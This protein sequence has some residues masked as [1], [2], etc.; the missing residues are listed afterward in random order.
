MMRALVLIC[1]VL[2]VA[3]KQEPREMK[4][5]DDYIKDLTKDGKP[6][7]KQA[8]DFTHPYPHLQEDN[9]F[10]NDYTKDSNSDEGE[11]AAQME[12]DRLRAMIR[13]QEKKLPLLKEKADVALAR[14]EDAMGQE[15]GV[16]K[17][18]KMEEAPAEIEVEEQAFEA[19]E[20]EKTADEEVKQAVA[21]EEAA[22]EEE[23]EAKKEEE[24]KVDPPKEI[25]KPELKEAP[26]QPVIEISSAEVDAAVANLKE[27]EQ[28]V[29]DAKEKLMKSVGERAAL[30]KALEEAEAGVAAAKEKVTGAQK[31]SEEAVSEEK[32]AEGKAASADAA[33]QKEVQDVDKLKADMD[34]AAY[35]IKQMRGAAADSEGAIQGESMF[36]SGAAHSVGSILFALVA[37]AVSL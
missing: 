33:Y 31:E 2:T 19:L 23:A 10:D 5:H 15:E 13:S 14:Y 17:E 8:E 30:K 35:K 26:A 11:W 3:G 18:V 16:H 34:A 36:H 32:V 37:A 1:A 22:V 12:Y 21:E 4:S 9:S 25:P 24:I 7:T 6:T 27:C 29:V 20:E 28:K